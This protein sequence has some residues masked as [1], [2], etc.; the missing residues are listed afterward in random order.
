MS[1]P[2]V[3]SEFPAI[4]NLSQK[5]RVLFIHGGGWRKGADLSKQP[6]SQYL[7]SKFTNFHCEGMPNT[8][9][10]EKCIFQQA[11][12]ILSFKPHIIV[13]K[14]QGGPTLLNLYQRGIYFGPAVITCPA[15]VPGI[16]NLILSTKV[17]YLIVG[18]TRDNEAR[19]D[20]IEALYNKNKNENNNQLIERIWVDDIHS[21]KSLLIDENEN[22]N[23]ID[24][25][26]VRDN[27]NDENGRGN[28][29]EKEEQMFRNEKVVK[30][31]LYQCV[32]RC[33]ESY[34]AMNENDRLPIDQFWAKKIPDDAFKGTY[35]W[36]PNN[37]NIK[38]DLENTR[39]KGAGGGNN[40]CCV[41]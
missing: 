10:F 23:G 9:E 21:L 17:P 19:P 36:L 35:D 22:D 33:W 13:T 2:E 31:T 12:A 30:I 25:G 26:N 3:N 41:L 38:G 7:G 27:M 18:G 14:S 34:L 15:V 39:H 6:F 40:C 8:S 16:D 5:L 32:K 20:L 1:N 24:N 28:I 4:D 11:N 37:S 29:E